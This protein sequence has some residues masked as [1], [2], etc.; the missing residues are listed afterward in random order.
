MIKQ[1]KDDSICSFIYWFTVWHNV[2]FQKTFVLPFH[3]YLVHFDDKHV[4]SS[5]VLPLGIQ[6]IPSNIY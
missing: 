6:L 3:L 4:N 2:T 1:T 5:T